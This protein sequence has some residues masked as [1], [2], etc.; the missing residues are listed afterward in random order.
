LIN[1]GSVGL[2]G[3]GAAAQRN[4]DVRWA[5]FAVVEVEGDRVDISLRRIPLDVEQLIDVASTSGMPEVEWWT[6]LWGH[7]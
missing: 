5:E 7:S 1:P 2:P 4:H 6:G 3:V